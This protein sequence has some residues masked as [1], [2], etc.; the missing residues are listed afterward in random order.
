[1]LAT[2]L[3]LK[4]A[5]KQLG[6]ENEDL[7]ITDFFDFFLVLQ[8]IQWGNISMGAAYSQDLVRWIDFGNWDDAKTLVS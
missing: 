4:Y 2:N 6:L 3:I 7:K 5:L 8:H 1:M